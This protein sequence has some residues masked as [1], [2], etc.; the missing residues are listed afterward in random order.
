MLWPLAPSCSPT[1]KVRLFF[2]L[3]K[4]FTNFNTSVNV[5]LKLKKALRISLK[6]VT[7]AVGMTGYILQSL[8]RRWT[9]LLNKQQKKAYDSL[10]TICPSLIKAIYYTWLYPN[11][12]CSLASFNILSFVSWSRLLKAFLSL[13]YICFGL[14][15]ISVICLLVLW[16]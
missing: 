12:W 3:C 6:S 5:M 10:R 4:R 11:L 2:E 8:L 1:A 15:T 13:S 16:L 7:F 9:L 14:A